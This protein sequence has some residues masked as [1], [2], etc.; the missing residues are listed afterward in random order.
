MPQEFVVGYLN[1]ESTRIPRI[2]Q[3]DITGV[4]KR[5]LLVYDRI[6]NLGKI[7]GVEFLLGALAARMFYFRSKSRTPRRKETDTD[8]E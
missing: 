8:S 7:G 5:D 6:F 4:D 1:F 2:V 3:V